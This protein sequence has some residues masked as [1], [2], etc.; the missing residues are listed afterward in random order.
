MLYSD[1]VSKKI[2]NL[3][4]PLYVVWSL[5][6]RCNQRCLYCQI[7][8]TKRQELNTRDVFRIIDELSSLGTKA[9][10]FSGGEPLLRDDLGIIIN[11]ALKAGIACIDINSNGSLVKERIGDIKD[12]RLLC[13]SLDGPQRVHD[14]IRGKG[15]YRKV[16][17]AARI[18]KK[19]KITV[20]FRTV[21]T[22]YNLA[23]TQAVLNLADTMNI[24]VIFQ[25]VTTSIYG[26]CHSHDL[27]ASQDD[28]RDTVR[29]L[30][31]EK[32]KGASA[33]SSPQEVLDYLIKWPK[34]KRIHC[35]SERMFF[36]LGPD[37]K[38][39]PCAWEK[40]LKTI[41]RVD[42]LKLG[43]LRAIKELPESDC[44][45]C[46]NTSSLEFIYRLSG[47]MNTHDNGRRKGC[48]KGDRNITCCD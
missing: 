16:V 29:G 39:Y 28:I 21:L 19:Y 13:L 12:I 47:L 36:H 5:T 40:D 14:R 1:T 26:T 41:D 15:A 4:V 45:G 7:W 9:I 44:N 37:G 34:T 8:K 11:H 30:L 6:Y 10:C 33:I 35:I 18:A 17:E 43:V 42:A 31:S 38:F 46:N 25:P 20:Y 3:R 32:K 24:K 27:S 2:G 48:L 23:Y 22:K